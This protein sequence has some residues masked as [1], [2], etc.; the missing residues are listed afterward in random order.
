[1]TMK[2]IGPALAFLLLCGATLAQAQNVMTIVSGDKQSVQR[3]GE[4]VPGG[5]ANFGAMSV[6]VKDKAG[7][8]VPGVRVNFQC[9]P[10]PNAMACQMDDN[11]SVG[12]T[13]AN[14]VRTLKSVR[15]YYAS[16]KMPIVV[17]GDNTNQVTFDLA[18]LDAPP[19]PAAVA[20]ATMAIGSGDG[21]KVARGATARGIPTARF[22]PLQV[23]VKDGAGKPIANARVV[24]DCGSKPQGLACQT[25][26]SGA[27]GATVYTDANGI[28]TANKMG[29]NSATAYYA[30]GPFTIV[31][32]YGAAN[33]TFKLTAGK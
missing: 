22:A 1:M 11:S 21:P 8:P 5:I 30:D 23:S 27:A 2:T 24:F 25:E 3:S 26:P 19:P 28:A 17:S 10:K 18:V 31:A 7:K 6:V 13:D 9:G 32:K 33:A 16:G 20:G 14:G 29:G 12:N 15:A 4:Q